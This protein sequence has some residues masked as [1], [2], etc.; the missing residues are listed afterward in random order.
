[1]WVYPVDGQPTLRNNSSQE[2]L[3]RIP[4][5]EERKRRKKKIRRDFRL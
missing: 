2:R 3:K 1:M 5:R 4:Q